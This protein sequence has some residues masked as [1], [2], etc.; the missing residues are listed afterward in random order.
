MLLLV[1]LTLSNMFFAEIMV[2]FLYQNNT[3]IISEEDSNTPFLLKTH[4]IIMNCPC[5]VTV[6]DTALV[7]RIQENFLLPLLHHSL[8]FHHEVVNR[9]RFFFFL[10]KRAFHQPLQLFWPSRLI[11]VSFFLS[12]PI[13]IDARSSL[14]DFNNFE[15]D[16]C[17]RPNFVAFSCCD[18]F[19]F[20]LT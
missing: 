6:E 19:F 2:S 7:N 15:N 12:S 10:F 14:S 16:D 5:F 18:T 20:S 11:H 1:K 17:R 8:V 4:N 9:L 3:I 13:D